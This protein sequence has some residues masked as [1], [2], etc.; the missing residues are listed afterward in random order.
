MR[1]RGLSWLAGNPGWDSNGQQNKGCC[2][3]RLSLVF[4]TS[5]LT[6]KR[7]RQKDQQGSTW[8]HAEGFEEC[9]WKAKG[10]RG[11]A[12]SIRCTASAFVLAILLPIQRLS[13][14]PHGVFSPASHFRE[15]QDSLIVSLFASAKR[16]TYHLINHFFQH[17]LSRHNTS[18]IVFSIPTA[19]SAL[20]LPRD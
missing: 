13:P 17:D 6:W 7:N 19:V 14:Q 3:R 20:R 18:A 1:R 8:S 4:W 11:R 15:S 10:R 5:C 2:N 16:L 12:N 9:P